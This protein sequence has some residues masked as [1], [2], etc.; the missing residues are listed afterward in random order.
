MK[1]YLEGHNVK[2]GYAV[3][4]QFT[5]CQISAMAPQTAL[6][7]PDGPVRFYRDRRYADRV[8]E[9]FNRRFATRK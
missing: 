3:S 5:E 9:R 7:E 4:V 2:R 8:I 1:L 6:I